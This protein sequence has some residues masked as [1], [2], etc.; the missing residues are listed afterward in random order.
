MNIFILKKK[1]VEKIQEAI[2][3][4]I[5]YY[6]SE[7]K[8]PRSFTQIANSFEFSAPTVRKYA[9]EYLIGEY[10]EKNGL[11]LYYQFIQLSCKAPNIW[12]Y[13]YLQELGKKRGLEENGIEGSLITTRDD[14]L[15]LI[16]NQYP[17][18]VKL[19][20]WCGKKDHESWETTG[21]EIKRGW[22]PK[23]FRERVSFSY[24]YLQELARLKGL[25]KTGIEGKLR[26]SKV[27]FEKKTKKDSPSQIKLIWWCGKEDHEPWEAKTMEIRGYGSRRGTWCPKCAIEKRS[28]S[29]E[30][31][32]ALAKRRGLE[33]TGIEGKLI[34]NKEKF[35]NSKW[36]GIGPSKI[37][38][39]W[40]CGK[41]KHEP[42]EAITNSISRGTWCPYCSQGKYEQICRW[43]FEQIFKRKFPRTSLYKVINVND[44]KMHLDGI[45]EVN[46]QGKVIKLAFEFNGYQHYIWPNIFHKT[47]EEFI[48]QKYRDGLKRNLCNENGIILIEFPYNVSPTMKEPKKIQK[49]I[50]HKFKKKTGI[51]MLNLRQYNYHN[52]NKETGLDKFF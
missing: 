51:K 18:R 11:K 46:I 7:S 47:Y 8:K 44:R 13:N 27:E 3:S 38:L 19:K 12:S 4:E 6:H 35:K 33:E 37:K 1:Q 14:F 49:Y 34:T 39:I 45:A 9:K 32:H 42:W 15:E 23:C 28:F 2:K 50:V 29:Y 20:W 10:G 36:Q 40:W 31:L 24:D 43:Y 26:T 17:S 48:K 30:D 16:Q 5:N 52:I 41:K 21:S 22:Y 25:K